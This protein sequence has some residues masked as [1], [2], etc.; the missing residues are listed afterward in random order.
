MKYTHVVRIEEIIKIKKRLLEINNF[1]LSDIIFTKN[2]DPVEI[3][4]NVL[5]EFKFTGLNNA[6]FITGEFYKHTKGI[7]E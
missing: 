7:T 1:N 4:E 5:N 6:D 2:G 3:N